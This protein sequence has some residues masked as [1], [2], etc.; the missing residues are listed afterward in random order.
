MSVYTKTGD[1]GTTGIHGGER[2]H[3]DDIRIEANG[4]IDELNSIIGVVRA[5]L[6]KTH[7]WQE[8]MY[9]LQRE[10]MVLMSLVATPSRI[11]EKNP[12]TFDDSLI[13]ECEK[14]MDDMSNKMGKSR[15][16]LL[17]GGNL[18][19]ANLHLARTFAR[20]AERRL[21]TLHKQDHVQQEILVFFNRLSDLFFVMSRYELFVNQEDEEVWK[22]F[23]YKRKKSKTKNPTAK[24]K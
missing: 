4:S 10:M 7:E 1:K 18:V 12:N 21:W 23:A 8:F 20:R 9:K 17:P 11:F 15:D 6:P 14:L 22:S 5:H 19:S 16:F 2:V 24:N 13:A 3:K